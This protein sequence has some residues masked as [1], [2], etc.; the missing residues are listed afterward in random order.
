MPRSSAG[1]EPRP[2]F[3]PQDE[4]Q[5]GLSP[6]EAA[7]LGSLGSFSRSRSGWKPAR[8]QGKA[9]CAL[10]HTDVA[11]ECNSRRWRGLCVG[12]PSSFGDLGESAFRASC[13]SNR[14]AKMKMPLSSATAG[15]RV[16]AFRATSGVPVER[17][18]NAH[19]EVPASSPSSVTREKVQV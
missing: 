6:D 16:P 8:S 13:P 1:C 18:L 9:C 5:E 2:S 15:P 3:P 10:S 11:A 19:V 14:S 4:R 17:S 7:S 12:L